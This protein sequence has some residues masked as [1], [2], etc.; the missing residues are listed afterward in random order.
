VRERY[1]EGERYKRDNEGKG[2]KVGER[3]CVE[4]LSN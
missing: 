1:K 4:L 2:R 3:A